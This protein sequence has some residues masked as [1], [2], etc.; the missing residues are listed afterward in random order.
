MHANL[1]CLGWFSSTVIL[2]VNHCGHGAYILRSNPLSWSCASLV[3]SDWQMC[4]Q[5][6]LCYCCSS[7]LGHMP[8]LPHH[9]PSLLSWCFY[10]PQ[11]L[12][13]SPNLALWLPAHLSSADKGI[14]AVL[15]AHFGIVYLFKLLII[16]MGFCWIAYSPA[17]KQFFPSLYAPTT[18]PD[19]QS[20]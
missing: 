13:L 8:S 9:H 4:K 14:T 15:T 1:A 16:P 20:G 11:V 19:P 18:P 12:R 5:P 6:H 3:V 17:P 7:N 10:Y 2:S